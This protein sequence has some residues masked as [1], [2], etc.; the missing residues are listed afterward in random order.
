MIPETLKDKLPP[1][2]EE[3]EEAAIGALL[4]HFS[5]EN[6]DKL[7]TTAHPED[8]YKTAHKNILRAILSLDERGEGVDLL[9]VTEELKSM[10]LLDKSGGASYIANLT[11]S[12]PSTA[13]LEY[14]AKIVKD[15]SVRRRLLSV[16]GEIISHSHDNS[17]HSRNIIENAEKRIFLISD[18]QQQGNLKEARDVVKLTVNAIEERYK[19]K[20]EFSGVPSGFPDLDSLTT[21]FQDSEMI[22]IGA[23]PSIG[24]T[25]FALSMAANIAIKQ[26]IP[27]GFFTLEMS[28]MSLML[29]LIAQES[30]INS[31]SLRTGMLSKKDF[32]KLAEAAGRIYESPLVIDDTPNIPLLDLRSQARR[33]VQKHGVRIIFIDYIGLVNPEEKSTPRHEQMAEISRSLKALA[34]ELN[35]PVVVLSQVGR[36]TEGKAPGLADLRESGAIEQDADIVMFLHRERIVDR[37]THD[38]ENGIETEIIV[39]KQR[40]GPTDTVKLL[41]MERFT[42]FESR[43]GETP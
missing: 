40:N 18:D 6:L 20:G 30:R 7:V 39:A 28:N 31:N 1:Y 16:A 4:L 26:K 32:G 23:R 33:M 36:Q 27:C 29:R 25:A 19:K 22:I 12:V 43:T 15:C 42:R 37:E 21:G 24:K 14:Y 13:N 11:S 35:I 2:N 8:F 34:R 17:Q 5:P 3:A 9:T 10:S 41:F 38:G